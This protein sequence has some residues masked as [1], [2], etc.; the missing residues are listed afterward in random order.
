MTPAKEQQ[1]KDWEAVL[2]AAI[3]QVAGFDVPADAGFFE[4]GLTSALVVG[5]FERLLDQLGPEVA[6]TVFFTYPTRRSLAAHLAERSA[7][8]A[9][10][11]RTVAEVAA[12]GR[13][14]ASA[15]RDLRSRMNQRRG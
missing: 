12:P 4:A 3:R 11:A 5:L 9:P 10:A 15:R 1:A 2:G 6:V 7:A 14:T 8:P 13:L